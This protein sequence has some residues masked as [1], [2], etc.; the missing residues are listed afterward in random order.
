MR[1]IIVS[2]CGQSEAAPYPTPGIKTKTNFH[3]ISVF[4]KETKILS[5]FLGQTT[6]TGEYPWDELELGKKT[7]IKRIFEMS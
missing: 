5:T 4:F 2:C 6:G 7:G 3:N 1:Q